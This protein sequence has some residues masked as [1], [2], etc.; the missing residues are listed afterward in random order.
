MKKSDIINM[1]RDNLFRRKARTFLSVLGVLIG[2][3]SIMIM[4]SI[5]VGM[6]RSQTAWIEE[7]GDLTS[8][9]VYQ[10]YDDTDVVLDAAAVEAIKALPGVESVSPKVSTDE[11]T[12]A[13]Y[14]GNNE[15]YEVLWPQICGL[16]IDAIASGDYEVIL[17]EM[18]K[19]ENTALIGEHF[20][21]MLTDTRRPEGNNRIEYYMY[22]GTDEEMPEPY[23]QLLGQKITLAA[24]DEEGNQLISREIKIAGQV[25]E[26]Y[27]LTYETGD[28]IIMQAK[29]LESFILQARKAMGSKK[30]GITY[31]TVTVG[32]ADIDEVTAVQSAIDDMGYQ[33]ESMKSLRESTQKEMAIIQL[34][35]GGIG[36]ISLFV[37]AIGIT[38]TMIMS[39]TERTKE[40]GI[41]KALGCYVYDIKRIF[42]IEAS[43]IGL[44]GGVL[45]SILS[46]IVSCIINLLAGM[47]MVGA[48]GERTYSTLEML[49]T[50]PERVSA[51]PLWLFLFGIGFSVAVGLLSGM[52][53]ANKAVKISALEAMKNE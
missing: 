24:L 46:F 39:V 30:N 1:C 8:I 43:A 48:N 40:I 18:P 23:M 41:M 19:G 52:Y 26:N 36:A 25:K 42:L 28:G 5:G 13:V 31:S 16:E 51:L 34:V 44:L 29:D 32:T 3:A 45:G 4:L 17:G 2:S 20:E 27:N 53:P 10:R 50:S 38:N 37:A 22:L 7:M 15:R 35:L 33:T 6:T 49:F 14:A 21:Y 12:L 11:L 9:K 47:S